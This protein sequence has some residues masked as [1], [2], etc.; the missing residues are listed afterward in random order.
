LPLQALDCDEVDGL[1]DSIDEWTDGLWPELQQQMAKCLPDGGDSQVCHLPPLR[2]SLLLRP[3][4]AEA[5]VRLQSVQRMALL[6]STVS[7]PVFNEV[8]QGT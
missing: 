2:S 1:E 4:L 8:A 7:A 6:C 5:N 3:R